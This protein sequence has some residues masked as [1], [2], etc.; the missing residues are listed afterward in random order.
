MNIENAVKNG[1]TFDG[2][3]IIKFNIF[4]DERG[5]FAER[6]HEP[7]LADLGIQET[8]VQDNH[9]RSKPSVVRGLHIQYNKPQGKLVGVIRGSIYDVAVDLRPRS[10]TF[11]QYFGIELSDSN[12]FML[13]I[14]PGFAHGFCVLGK[15]MADVHYKVTAPYNP[16]GETGI[17][18]NDPD[19]NIHWPLTEP[20]LVS[21]KDKNLS[22]MTQFS[23]PH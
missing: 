2:L 4:R 14:P 8:F 13:W 18:W 9:S 20:P 22:K 11:G 5:F 7:R 12:G 19:L 10:K 1:E 3:K 23:I 21:L 15:E 17:V 6:Y 16:A